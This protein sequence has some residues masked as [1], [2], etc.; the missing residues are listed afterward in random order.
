MYIPGGGGLTAGS[1]A[2]ANDHAHVPVT[3][4]VHV[5]NVNKIN[6]NVN[7]SNNNLFLSLSRLRCRMSYD[8]P[9]SSVGESD[10]GSMFNSVT[11]RSLSKN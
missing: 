4:N 11:D 1:P 8:A 9:P 7:G 5:D 3:N 6:F 10:S 2:Q